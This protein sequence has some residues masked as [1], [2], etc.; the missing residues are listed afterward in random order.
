MPFSWLGSW[1]PC[2]AYENT[3]E[4]ILG[5]SATHLLTRGATRRLLDQTQC[6]PQW[7]RCLHI[8]SCAHWQVSCTVE[9]RC[10]MEDI[11]LCSAQKVSY[12]PGLMM[13]AG[14]YPKIGPARCIYRCWAFSDELRTLGL[15]VGPARSDGPRGEYFRVKTNYVFV[16]QFGS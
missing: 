7:K 16:Q 10:T 8:T 3:I 14:R 5:P 1:P 9:A 4:L 15:K 2:R 11:V 12:T 13:M 6:S